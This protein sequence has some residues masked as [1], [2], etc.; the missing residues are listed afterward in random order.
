MMFCK[1]CGA[2]L[3][4]KG[5]NSYCKNCNKEHEGKIELKE[6]GNTE[7]TVVHVIE[8]QLDIMPKCSFYCKKCGNKEAYHW[9]VQTRRSD[10]APTIFMRCTKCGWTRRGGR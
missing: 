10:E 3:I 9:D 6:K 8:K 5:K 4:P 7:K 2:V 1:K